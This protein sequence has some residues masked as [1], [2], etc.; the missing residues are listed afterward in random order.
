MRREKSSSWPVHLSPY[1]PP[2][3]THM[4]VFSLSPTSEGEGETERGTERE[5]RVNH[6]SIKEGE[7]FSIWFQ[8][9]QPWNLHTQSYGP[10]YI[11]VSLIVYA[12]LN[13]IRI[14]L[15]WE[16]CINLSYVELVHSAFR[17]TISF[18][19]SVESFY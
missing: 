11:P 19:F 9:L 18:Y 3:V 14:L 10:G 16:T 6:W 12:K 8:Y 15:L 13:R 2:S 1:C 4:K 5:N 7:T 17:S